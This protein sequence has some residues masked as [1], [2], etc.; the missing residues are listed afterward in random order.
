M[1]R[2]LPIL[3]CF[4]FYSFFAFTQ[5]PDTSEIQ[6]VEIASKAFGT[7]I[8][9]TPYQINVI[10]ANLIRRTLATNF[11]EVLAFSGGLRTETDCQTCNYTQ[12]RMNGLGGA[13]TQILINGRPLF[14]S[15][16]GLYGLEQI[17]SNSIEQVEIVRGGGSVAYGA[18]AI[19]GTVN[20]ITKTPTKN[21]LAFQQTFSLIGMKAHDWNSQLNGAFVNKKKTSA[22]SLFGA[23]KKRQALDVNGDGFSEI[24]L[25]NGNSL[26]ITYDQ[27]LFKQFNFQFNTFLLNEERRGGN[28][29]HLSPEQSDQCELR[30]QLTTMNQVS[31]QW[32]GKKIS[33]QL[34]SGF[35]AT[36]RKHYTGVNQLDGW[37]TTSNHTV[38][39]GLQL[40]YK[41]AFL[42]GKM[43]WLLGGEHLLDDVLDRVDAYQYL[44]DQR[45][46]QKAVYLQN[47]WEI[48]DKWTVL[49][50][51]RLNKHSRVE[52][53]Y[54]TPR[55]ALLFKPTNRLQMRINYGKG[56]KAAQ[57]L[58]TDMHMAFANGGVSTVQTDLHLK[59]ESSNALTATVDW[60]KR[61]AAFAFSLTGNA[62]YTEL[63]NPFVL[64]EIGQDSLGNTT[65]FRTNGSTATVKG[66]SLEV[67]I[68]WS[69]FVQMDAGFTAQQANFTSPQIWSNTVQAS[70]QFLRTPSDYGFLSASLFPKSK[71]TGGINVV[72]TG[73]MLVPHFGGAPENSIDQLHVSKAFVDCSIRLQH[74][75]HIHRYEQN[76]ILGLALQNV[77]N[78]Y[79]HDFDTTQNRDSNY[80][81]GPSKPRTFQVSLRYEIGAE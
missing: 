33:V 24:P 62:F 56:V 60:N 28:K 13:Y 53:M 55:L 6:E 12:L 40:N 47:Q 43:W 68:L 57:V 49:G 5:V 39:T 69:K 20:V 17:P 9:S 41:H 65:L 25:V 79:Q 23:F 48:S 11:C 18:N 75:F 2:A 73:S 64:E 1:N 80:I 78:A 22:L 14:S 50:G 58:E 8:Q 42:T 72:Y 29:F 74:R 44:I 76:I 4:Q 59:S 27:K 32:N 7:S 19:A 36:Q 61:F 34:F 81:Y 3:F 38:Q 10:D 70:K 21:N 30:D 45:I 51:I 66:F 15:L 35:Q 54:A 67:K 31:L 63:R 26:G 77:F 71:T 37:G 46:D 52:A 16:M